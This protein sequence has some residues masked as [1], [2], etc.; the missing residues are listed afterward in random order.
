MKEIIKSIGDA[1]IIILPLILIF[2]FIFC[3]FNYEYVV[4][5][6]DENIEMMHVH[7]NNNSIELRE[8]AMEVKLLAGDFGER[9]YIVIYENGETEKFSLVNLNNSKAIALTNYVTECSKKNDMIGLRLIIILI[10][11]FA[12]IYKIRCL[13]KIEII[14]CEE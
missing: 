2:Y 8:G 11:I 1:I 3:I 12:S 10:S 9:D 7:F 5:I 4:K 6:D 14:E 13:G